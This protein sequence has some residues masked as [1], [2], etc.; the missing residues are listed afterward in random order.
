MILL[1]MMVNRTKFVIR[2]E[3]VMIFVARSD[4]SSKFGTRVNL[5]DKSSACIQ[6]TFI[7]FALRGF[8]GR[9]EEF[10]WRFFV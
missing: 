8:S 1:L 9:S 3:L 4:N 6:L 5:I 2:T 7:E 10:C